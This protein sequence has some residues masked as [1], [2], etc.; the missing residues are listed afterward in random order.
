MV[1]GIIAVSGPVFTYT[2]T[3]TLSNNGSTTLSTS[4][5]FEYTMSMTQACLSSQSADL[6]TFGYATRDCFSLLS[7]RRLTLAPPSPTSPAPGEDFSVLAMGASASTVLNTAGAAALRALCAT[8]IVLLFIV[9]LFCNQREG[10]AARAFRCWGK[11]AGAGMGIAAVVGAITAG[12]ILSSRDSLGSNPW[13]AVF[14]GAVLDDDDD[15]GED[16]QGISN[17]VAGPLTFVARRSDIDIASGDGD[18]LIGASFGLGVASAVMALPVALAI[19]CGSFLGTGAAGTADPGAAG[20]TAD[21]SSDTATGGSASSP[22]SRT[23]SSSNPV[24]TEKVVC[25]ADKARYGCLMSVT[26]V[27]TRKRY[28]GKADALVQQVRQVRSSGL[29]ETIVE[30]LMASR[31]KIVRRRVE[32]I[33]KGSDSGSTPGTSKAGAGAVSSATA[34]VPSVPK[35][36]SSDPVFKLGPGATTAPP[37]PASYGTGAAV[38]PSGYSGGGYGGTGRPASTTAPGSSDV[39]GGFAL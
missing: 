8:I 30:A 27:P 4:A 26:S 28:Q 16:L 32:E 3:G 22:S 21:A 17:P 34:S 6:L 13:L 38:A 11:F 18:D 14:R 29:P 37:P 33:L 25:E 9:G 5:K 10:A 15:Y 36:S 2:A 1:I 7:P 20:T 31:P 39:G 24:A 23:R 35:E 19:F 12:M